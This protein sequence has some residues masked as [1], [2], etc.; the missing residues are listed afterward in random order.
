MVGDNPNRNRD[1]YRNRKNMSFGAEGTLSL[2]ISIPIPISI[3]KKENPKKIFM[4]RCARQGMRVHW[5]GRRG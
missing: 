4:L 5:Q 2:W 1:R 3:L